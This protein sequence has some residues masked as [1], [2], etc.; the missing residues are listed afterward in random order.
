MNRIKIALLFFAFLVI[1]VVASANDITVSNVSLTGRVIAG[2]NS[3]SNYTMVK[4]DLSWANSWRTS[5]AP[6]NWDAAWVFVKY[7][8]VGGNWQHA[9]LNSS[10]HIEGTGTAITIS[11]GLLT[12]SSPFSSSTNPAV[13]VF[14]HRS[15][16]GSGTLSVTS[17]QI[18]WNYGENGVAD[19]ASVEVKV[20]AIEMV[21]VPTGNFKV[22]SPDPPAGAFPINPFPSFTNGSYT[23]GNAIPLVITNSQVQIGAT[24][25]KLYT[26]RNSSGSI[27]GPDATLSA[28]FPTGYAAYYCMKYELSQGMYRD[29][30]NALSPTQQ[31]QRV[32]STVLGEYA[33]TGSTNVVN[34]S[35]IRVIQANSG[36]PFVFAC[37]IITSASPF[38]T[39]DV[40]QSNDGESIPCNFIAW[41]DALAFLDWSG[42][43]PMTELEYEKACRGTS[44]P[45]G[46]EFAWGHATKNTQ[47]YTLSNLNT[48]S[49]SI[50]SGYAGNTAYGNAMH[51][52]VTLAI[53]GPLRSGIF[54]GHSWNDPPN[55]PQ[56]GATFYGIM[57]MTGNLEEYTVNVAE[58]A[59]RSYTG[60][61]GDGALDVTGSANVS[62]WPPNSAP[63]GYG[64]RGGYYQG[65]KEVSNRSE[66][67]LTSANTR[68][69]QY[70][71]RGV[72]TL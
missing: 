17:A 36:Q 46:G 49:E 5:S 52:G 71:C 63:Y 16:N 45:I 43:R 33:L 13:G 41:T 55:R 66:A 29:F 44:E 57:E 62:G 69:P 27:I 70:G 30:L 20:F 11:P 25:G 65:L 59:G 9:K 22:G 7:R 60:E 47:A 38:L 68:Q 19:N 54:S 8:V 42:L 31:V 2:A 35:G 15:S 4:F 53:Q 6:N 61:H 58:T 1:S 14:I 12:P 3:S 48:P 28:S 10:G 40:N 64:L 26:T 37:D 56:S 32:R 34:R 24:S 51:P 67:A 72:R 18:R 23:S 21:Y 39:S 50:S